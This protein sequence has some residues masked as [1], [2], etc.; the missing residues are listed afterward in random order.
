MLNPKGSILS[1]LLCN[2]FYGNLESTLLADQYCNSADSL[3]LR[4][5]DD[6]LLITTAPQGKE[7]FICSNRGCI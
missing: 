5:V 3:L 2:Y 6:F 4:M 7:G 1:T